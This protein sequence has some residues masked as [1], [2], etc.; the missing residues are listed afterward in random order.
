MKHLIYS[1]T[2]LLLLLGPL[3]YS[4]KP[5]TGDSPSSPDGDPIRAYLNLNNISTIF[6]NTGISD[7][8]ISE[9]SSGFVFPKGSNRTAVYISGLLWGAKIPGDPQV[10]VG[11]SAYREGLQGGRILPNGE[12]EDPGDLHVRIYRVRPDVYP[13]GPWVDL[14]VEAQDEM[15]SEA[16][17]RAQY[18][19]DWVEWRA[20]DGA[21][22]LDGNNN[23]QFEPDPSSND[24]PGI[25]GAAQTI[26]FVANDQNPGKTLDLYGTLPIGIE[27]QATMWEYKDSVGFDNLFFRKYKL[28]NKTNL[29]GDPTTFED[30]YISMWSDID[31]G[32]AS[33]DYAGCD[34]L[35][36]LGF[37]YNASDTDAVYSPLPPPAV[38]FDLIRGPIVP[39]NPG[40]DKNRNGVDDTQ[41]FALNEENQRLYGFINLPMTAFY[42][43]TNQDSLITDP[44][45]GDPQGANQFYN[46]MQGK[47]GLTGEYFINPITSLPTTFALPGNPVT[48]AGWIDGMLQGP[49]DRRIG[50]STGPLQMEPGD[51]Q[52]VVIA[53]IAGG[54]TNGVNHLAAI[55]LVKYYST[56]AQNFYDTRFPLP[57]SV[58][59]E[60]VTPQTFE[61][62]QNFPNPFNPS[63]T[64]KFSIPVTLSGVEGS[65]FTLKIFNALGEEVEVLLDK[66]FTAGTYKVEWNATGLPSGVYL[67]RLQAGDLIEI[68]KMLLLK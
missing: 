19:L 25:D 63:T 56:I 57:V 45:Q 18:E 33:D 4:Q 34:T 41:D 64:I 20:Q 13:G 40:E 1:L 47:I 16:E 21:P 2:L 12:V 26:W 28:I 24:V 29:L 22:Y 46:F 17:V 15:K 50:L 42:Y 5:V 9:S 36:G 32:D 23:G 49:G 35:L 53:E 11:G 43:F 67:Y 38:G 3:C 52:T 48:G 65:F 61:L 66:E 39:G 68:K 10:R 30:M 54:A 8:D 58:N 27:Y 44:P 59:D 62:D 37:G 31:I 51:T 6:K 7:I 14:S 60:A 55:D